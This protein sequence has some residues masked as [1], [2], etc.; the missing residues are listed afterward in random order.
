VFPEAGFA[1]GTVDATLPDTDKV[2]T[3]LTVEI[4]A[5]IVQSI[6]SSGQ[7]YRWFS[8]LD[9]EYQTGVIGILLVY[10]AISTGNS[11]LAPIAPVAAPAVRAAIVD[12]SGEDE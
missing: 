9:K 3:E 2:T 4:P 12:T 11:S 1:E 8:N 5:L 10:V 6:L 7:A